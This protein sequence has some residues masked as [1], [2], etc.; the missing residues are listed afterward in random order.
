MKLTNNL[1]R[2]KTLLKNNPHLRDDDNKLIANIWWGYLK[3]IN[4]NVNE[5]SA[6]KFLALFS[7]GK[8]PNPQSIRRVRR[9]F[10]EEM[11][12]LRGEKWKLRHKE[13][14]NVKKELYETPEFYQ[15]GTP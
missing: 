7:D 5:I 2:V 4:S 10:Q 14:E 11:P 9:K 8:L 15:G 12:E 1:D 13:Q 3:K 6:V